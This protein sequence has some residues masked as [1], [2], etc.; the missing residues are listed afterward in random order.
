MTA[1]TLTEAQ[2]NLDA[3][4]AASLRI[5]KYGSASIST[6]AGSRTLTNQSAAEVR[7]MI[8]YWQRKV[9][10]LSAESDSGESRFSLANFDNRF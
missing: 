9:V 7:N 6:S 1:I 2:Q 4:K 10:E 5:A 3:W 8:D